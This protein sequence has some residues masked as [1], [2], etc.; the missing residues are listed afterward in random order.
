M[1][2]GNFVRSPMPA[3]KE[4]DSWVVDLPMTEGAYLWIWQPNGGNTVP[5]SLLTGIKFVRPLQRIT[6][7][8]PGR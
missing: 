1:L 5:D 7:A 8:Y 4:G 6:N 2:N 3:T